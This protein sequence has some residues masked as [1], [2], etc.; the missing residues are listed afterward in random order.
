MAISGTVEVNG[1][2][3]MV[4]EFTLQEIDDFSNMGEVSQAELMSRL[5]AT[6][7]SVDIDFIKPLAPSEL[8]PLV[9]K[10]LEV[11]TSFFDQ[12]GAAGMAEAADGL[13]RLIKGIF[14]VAFLP[15][16]DPATE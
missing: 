4:R 15:S 13:A 3:V 7:T 9:D 5:I 8:Q 1:Q 16:S 11:N 6:A 14:I 10:M 2:K 12:A